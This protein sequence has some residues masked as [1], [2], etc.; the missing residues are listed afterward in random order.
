MRLGAEHEL[1][2]LFEVEGNADAAGQ[3][4]RTTLATF[5]S[6]RLQLKNEDSKLPFLANATPVYD[7]FI[8]FLVVRGKVEAALLLADQSRARTLAQG[9][10]MKGGRRANLGEALSPRAVAQKAGATLLFYWMGEKR[11]YL[12]TVTPER[13]SLSP[14]PKAGEI[15]P[16]VERYLG[17]LLGPQDP[18]ETANEDGRELFQLLVAPA[19]RLIR[20][21]LPV[22]V[23][24]DGAL[25]KLNFE[26]LLAPG[27]GPE[28][29]ANSGRSPTA[30]FWID[31]AT[32]LSAPS[33]AMLA[34]AKPA[35]KAGQNL[36]L[37][38]NP[39]SPSEE[40]PSLPLFGFEM[41]QVEKHFAANDV[42][43]FAGQR[44]SPA[45]YLSSS[46]A[47]YSYIHFVT[48]AIASRADPLDSAIILSESGAGSNSFKLYARDIMQR[49][50]DA[51]L[52]TIS[53][54][55][56]SGTRT[57]AGEGLVGLSWAFLRAGAHNTIG[58]LWEVSDDST[59]ILMDKLYRG[60]AEGATPASA[61]RRAKLGL[62]HSPGKFHS[63][64]YWAPF[65][66][67]T[68]Q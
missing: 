4:Y 15:A 45:A 29:N 65:Q 27:P 18:L 14:V 42:T 64:F 47:R 22:I 54:C 9:L 28:T 43:T 36:L 32:V 57:Y 8:H 16:M 46:P 17:A 19:A 67:Y 30:H 37:I 48:H 39:V 66:L 5:E 11:S 35:R 56:G 53:A 24:A 6:A 68:R 31:D 20:G 13:I 38:G 33:M 62:L 50:I 10:G 2:R 61:L 3:M 25:N 49:P 41:K 21:K 7:D 51:K 34:A 23:F 55:Y 59:P 60:L 52:V 12:W 44:A 58:A 40:F 63:P 26:T 1:A